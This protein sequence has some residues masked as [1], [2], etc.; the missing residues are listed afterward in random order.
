MS[1]KFLPNFPVRCTIKGVI[2]RITIEL[3]LRKQEEGR[4]G[5]ADNENKWDQGLEI[6][7]SKKC[8][9]GCSNESG[10]IGKWLGLYHICYGCSEERGD[11]EMAQPIPHF[12]SRA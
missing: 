5:L 4:G 8:G 3:K 10:G 9:Y 7:K 6:L 1:R 11:G 12:A 2:I